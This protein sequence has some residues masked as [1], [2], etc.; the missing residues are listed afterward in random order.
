MQDTIYYFL[1]KHLTW[2]ELKYTFTKLIYIVVKHI[3]KNP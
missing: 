2:I 3:R 1:G